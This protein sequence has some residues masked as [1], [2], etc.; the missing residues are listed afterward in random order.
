MLNGPGCAIASSVTGG[1]TD[2]LG[3][4][5]S[6]SIGTLQ[7][8]LC[9]QLTGLA[10]AAAWV[11]ISGDRV[12]NLATLAAATGA[13]LGVA[14]SVA[15]LFQAMVIG[16]I[17]IVAPISAT[18]AGLP[19][20]VGVLQGEHP[21][22][23]Q[24]A[25]MAM[26]LI[27]IGLAAGI[28]L[29]LTATEPGARLAIV[30]ALGAGLYFWLMDPA[31]RAGVP[32]ALLMNRAVP[33]L[34]LLAVFGVRRSSPDLWLRPQDMARITATAVLGCSSIA[35]YGVAT[36]HGELAIVSILGSLYPAVTVLLA[37]VMLSERI[38]PIQQ[39]GVCATLT[40]VALLAT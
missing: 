6:R 37:R 32:W 31:S 17:S 4:T 22:A 10:L 33:A 27:G 21:T 9:T 14:L 38:R 16:T 18:G 34:V 25:G 12:P 26:A 24:I 39:V 23:L 40:G 1:A 29:R 15:A 7:L 36:R 11:T 30:A 5:T 20:L 13:G 8:M 28:R 3:G 2:F 19:V 35:L